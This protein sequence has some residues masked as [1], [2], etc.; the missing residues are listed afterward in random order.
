MIQLISITDF[1]ELF[2]RRAR[3]RLTSVKMTSEIV[4]E[5]TLKLVFSAKVKRARP[6]C[7]S[8]VDIDYSSWLTSGNCGTTGALHPQE[9][10]AGSGEQ[11]IAVAECSRSTAVLDTRNELHN[12]VLVRPCLIRNRCIARSKII[13]AR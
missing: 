6:Q 5:C 9:K 2:H 11:G 8:V 13:L 1:S 7:S 3:A 4:R 12:R 10:D